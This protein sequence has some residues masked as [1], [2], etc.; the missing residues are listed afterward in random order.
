MPP[1]GGEAGHIA[2]EG[3]GSV[4]IR[5]VDSDAVPNGHTF[6]LTFALPDMPASVESLVGA[7][8]GSAKPALY[9]W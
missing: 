7:P 3:I 4:K 5:V 6:K 2:G 8:I 9:C 1:S